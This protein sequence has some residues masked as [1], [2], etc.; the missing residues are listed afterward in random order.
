MAAHI[1]AMAGAMTSKSEQGKDSAVDQRQISEEQVVK[2]VK[3]EIEEAKEMMKDMQI[4]MR[5][6]A[7][8]VA[9]PDS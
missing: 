8:K 6:F 3:K 9:G 4:M 7:S 2:I 1:G 5:S